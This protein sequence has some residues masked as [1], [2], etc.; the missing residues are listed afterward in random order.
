LTNKNNR[1]KVS[2]KA[3]AMFYKISTRHMDHKGKLD[4]SSFAEAVLYET[5]LT[6]NP[7]PIQQVE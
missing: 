3:A 1:P 4:L 6:G 7:H 5:A 2:G